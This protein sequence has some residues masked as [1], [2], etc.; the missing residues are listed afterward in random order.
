MSAVMSPARTIAVPAYPRRVGRA[1][2]EG[3]G[4]NLDHPV[5]LM[6]CTSGAISV[7]Q[8][9]AGSRRSPRGRL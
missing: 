7:R 8:V 4:T 6:F 5:T 9:R 2:K 3:E 1:W